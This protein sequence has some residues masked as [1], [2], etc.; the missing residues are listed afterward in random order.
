MKVMPKR[1]PPG[2]AEFRRHV[3]KKNELKDKLIIKGIRSIS[4]QVHE[5]M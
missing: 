3:T 4:T 2:W 1:Q 5:E